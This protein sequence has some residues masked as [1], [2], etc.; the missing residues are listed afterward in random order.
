MH[1]VVEKSDFR[2]DEIFKSI[3]SNKKKEKKIAKVN[4]HFSFI[5]RTSAEYYDI[6]LI[7]C[8]YKL[9]IYLIKS[10][11]VKHTQYYPK[12]VYYL[13]GVKY[14]ISFRCADCKGSGFTQP[15]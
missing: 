11:Y 10:Y 2:A 1:F 14:L 12:L 9:I 13:D 4:H 15:Q 8:R 7:I 5:N 6:K 3:I